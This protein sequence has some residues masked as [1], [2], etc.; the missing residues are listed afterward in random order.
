MATAGDC[1]DPG[2]GGQEGGRGWGGGDAE[3]GNGEEET[4]MGKWGGVEVL[5]KG[6]E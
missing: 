3:W 5:A 6:R 2:E 1:N 4:W